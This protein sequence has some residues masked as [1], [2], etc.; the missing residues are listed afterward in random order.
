MNEAPTTCKECARPIT[1]L[2]GSHRRREYC[3]DTCKQTAY[4]A[5]QEE[6]RKAEVCQHWTSY[7]E[8]TQNQLEWF[9]NRYGRDFAKMIADLITSECEYASQGSVA[10][11]VTPDEMPPG[12]PGQQ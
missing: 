3:D 1:Q 6:K 10:N 12:V 2:E 4:R 9:M 7:S 5:S 8:K 11:K